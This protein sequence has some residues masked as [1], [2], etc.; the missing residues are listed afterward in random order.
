LSRDALM[1]L[2]AE[3]GRFG[4]HRPSWRRDR[5]CRLPRSWMAAHVVRA[6]SVAL[7]LAGGTAC[8][9]T[10]TAPPSEAGA[11]DA[12]GCAEIRASSYDQ[13]CKSD[14]DC[15]MVNVGNACVECVFACGE[16]VGAINVGALAQYMADVDKTPAGAALCGCGLV[17][18]P[19]LCCRSGQC[20]ADN[21]CLSL[22]GSTDAADAHAE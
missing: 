21:E 3:G 8:T 14:S 13:S 7:L 2:E 18:R 4:H 22:D 16:H 15:A 17:L 19:P 10:N 1:A 12:A 20:H 6:L 5:H 11:S 9:S